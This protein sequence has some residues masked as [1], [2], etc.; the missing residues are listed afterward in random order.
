[1]DKQR[2]TQLAERLAEVA[3][4]LTQ[5]WLA[6][7]MPTSSVNITARKGIKDFYQANK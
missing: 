3:Y 6:E 7:G 1:M 2:A 4:D 5:D